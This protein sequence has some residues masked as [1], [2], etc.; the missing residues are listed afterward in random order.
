MIRL[1]SSAYSS[2]TVAVAEQTQSECQ[3]ACVFVVLG[4]LKCANGKRGIVK[5]RGVENAELENK[6][7]NSQ[8]CKTQDHHLW[9][10]IINVAYMNSRTNGYLAL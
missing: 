3:F 7:P 4:T 1:S 8:G 6:G 9:N 5:N 2:F 10:V